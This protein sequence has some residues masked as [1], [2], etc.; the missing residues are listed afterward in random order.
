MM[1]KAVTSYVNAP[2]VEPLLFTQRGKFLNIR[3]DSPA[4]N[5]QTV[6]FKN[7]LYRYINFFVFH[8]NFKKNLLML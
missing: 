7:V 2:K 8:Q 4:P 3:P 5:G 1:K 6:P